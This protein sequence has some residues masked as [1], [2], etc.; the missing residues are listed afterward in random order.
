ML[1]D[2]KDDFIWKEKR[3][4]FVL[5]VVVC[6]V[7][8][9]TH[10]D[11]KKGKDIYFNNN[12]CVQM[13]SQ[14]FLYLTF[15]PFLSLFIINHPSSSL[16]VYTHTYI[17]NFHTWLFTNKKKLTS[18]FFYPFICAPTNINRNRKKNDKKHRKWLNRRFH[19][20]RHQITLPR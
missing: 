17:Y 13:M 15:I 14:M 9:H 4:S 19:W 16:Y 5:C 3:F 2:T 20:K 8:I 11:T 7:H 18:P 1:K 6:I 12:E 10:T